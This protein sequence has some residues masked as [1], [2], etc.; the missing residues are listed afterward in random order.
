[1]FKG[2]NI[3]VTG[4]TGSLGQGL[5]DKLI[6]CNPNKL[7]VFSRRDHDQKV[8]MERIDAPCMRYWIGDIRDLDRLRLAFKDIDYVIHTA[9][10]KH[11]DMG[12]SNPLEYKHTIVDGA[13]NIIQAAIECGVERVIALSTDKA[14]LVGNSLIETTDGTLKLNKIVNSKFNNMVKSFN[15]VTNELEEKHVY[16]WYK[17]SLAGRDLYYLS[18]EGAKWYG[19]MRTHLVGT[20][21]HPILTNKGWKTLDSITI[22]DKLVTTELQPSGKQLAVFVGTLLGDASLTNHINNGRSNLTYGHSEKQAN[23]INLKTGALGKLIDFKRMDDRHKTKFLTH[24]SNT[25]AF[26]TDMRKIFYPNGIKI[27]PRDIV[28]KVMESNLKLFLATLIQDDGC[29]SYNNLRIATHSFTK[30]D[31]EWLIGKFNEFGLECYIYH[32][33]YKDAVYNEI[34]FTVKGTKLV[35]ELISEYI[36]LDYKIPDKFKFNKFNKSLWEIEDT[37]PYLGTP[38]IKKVDKDL[39]NPNNVFCIDVEDNHNFIVSNMVVHNCAPMNTYG[40]CKL[41]SDKLFMAANTFS[42]TEFSVI[43]YGN[44]I[45]SNGSVVKNLQTD[46]TIKITDRTMTRFWITLDHATNLIIHLLDHMQGGEMLIPKL[47]SMNVL[48]FLKA[49]RPDATKIVDIPIRA[50]EKIH[51][52]MFTEEDARLALEFDLYYIIYQKYPRVRTW[53]GQL[54]E[55]FDVFQYRSNDNKWNLCANEVK[56]MLNGTYKGFQN[57]I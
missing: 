47:P 27:I 16:N 25:S 34:R 41:M 49:V 20:E 2:K 19:N 23:W 50:G 6:K 40:A 30:D 45:G 51:E 17:N 8:M 29:K 15:E 11:V 12:E 52:S 9:A 35:Y 10:L 43:R 39:I 14:C 24:C 57:L 1:M 44:V 48:E 55:S 26:M 13:E 46:D 4:G 37:L 21:D 3:L 53:G 54:G 31:V 28:S 5:I 56:D 42:Q 22:N 38:I 33:K 7:I 18:Y 32:P 36:I